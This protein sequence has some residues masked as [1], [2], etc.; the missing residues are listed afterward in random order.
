M[1]TVNMLDAFDIIDISQPVSRTTACFPGDVPFSRDV[2]VTYDASQV[3]NLC[4][5]TMSPHVGTHADAPV[6]IHGDVNR[7]GPQT[8]TIGQVSLSP[9]IGP[10]AIVDVSPWEGPITWPQ[11]AEALS[12]YKSL[13]SRILFKTTQN[14]RYDVFEEQYASLSAELI[15]ELAKLGVVLVGLDTPSVDAVDSK[16]LDTHHALLAAGMSWLENLDLTAVAVQK[17]QPQETFLV[18]LPLKLM[19]L[20]ASPVRA[21]LLKPR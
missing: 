15:Q 19:E 21:V 18:A 8:E 11:V 3:I 6:H 2:T 9:F 10:A 4:A 17:G 1:E 14:I 12:L 13:P 20:E 5:F 16:T 7:P